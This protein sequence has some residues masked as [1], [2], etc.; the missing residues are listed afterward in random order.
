MKIIRTEKY[1]QVINSLDGKSKQSAKNY[2]YRLVHPYTTKI[3]SDT[4]WQPISDIWNTFT[5]NNIEWNT[6]RNSQYF[7]DEQGNLIRKEWYFIIDF[8]NNRNR[9]TQIIGTITAAGAGS[10]EDPLN[11]YDVTVVMN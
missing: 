4:A 8:I 2:L 11:R 10:V 3:Y 1:S 7:K 5:N 6:T 9:P